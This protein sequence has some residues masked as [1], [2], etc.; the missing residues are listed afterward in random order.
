M[1]NRIIITNANIS[2]INDDELYWLV[3]LCC[4]VTL[5]NSVAIQHDKRLLVLMQCIQSKI[6]GKC[7]CMAVLGERC[8]LG[9]LYQ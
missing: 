1:E 4:F 8:C 9:R 2:C 3:L 5:L 6:P 7:V